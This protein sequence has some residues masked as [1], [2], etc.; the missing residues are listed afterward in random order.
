MRPTRHSLPLLCALIAAP[1]L[2]HAHILGAEH[3]LAAGLLHPLTGID[4]LLTLLAA[5]F[6][7][8]RMG[9]SAQWMIPFAMLAAL[10]G[11][12]LLGL[13]GIHWSWVEPAVWSSVPF[14]AWLALRGRTHHLSLN[15]LLAATV[16]ILHGFAHVAGQPTDHGLEAFVAGVLITS[17]ALLGLGAALTLAWRTP[18][19]AD[20]HHS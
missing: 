8:R 18:Q 10:A 17:T 4:H 13:A 2:S 15:V 16:G 9:G 5:G 7:A 1:A 19:Q 14:M 6:W 3:G 20:M 12:T 11:G